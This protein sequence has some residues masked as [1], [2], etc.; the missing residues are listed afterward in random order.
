MGKLAVRTVAQGVNE[1][2]AKGCA[3]ITR[4]HTSG[5]VSG[6]HITGPLDL[7]RLPSPEVTPN[8]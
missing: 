6:I 5:P 8:P 1:I 7:E 4:Q 3:V 2:I